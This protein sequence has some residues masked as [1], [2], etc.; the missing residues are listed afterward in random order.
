MKCPDLLRILRDH[1]QLVAGDWM[2]RAST[3]DKV[4]QLQAGSTD[5]ALKQTPILGDP[6]CCLWVDGEV[7]LTERG[8]GA[9]VFCLLND[10]LSSQLRAKMAR[11]LLRE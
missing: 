2:I 10:P 4:H 9:L 1:G 3:I 5:K 8:Y 11:R 7:A 6:T